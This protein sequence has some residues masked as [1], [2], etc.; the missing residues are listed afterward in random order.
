MGDIEIIPVEARNDLKKFINLP[1]SIYPS[2][3]N[4]VP[5][6]K[7]DLKRLLNTKKHPFWEFSKRELFIA[8]RCGKPI[9][10]IAAIVDENYNKYHQEKMGIWGFF[11]GY[12][13]HEAAKSLFNAAEEW[14]R[15]QGMEFI[16]GPLNPS[17]NYEVGLLIEGFEHFPA[18]MMPW[19]F[20][21]Y[22]ELVE[23]SGYTKEK[24]LFTFRIHETDPAGPRIERL[25]KRLLSKGH[26]TIRNISRKNYDSEIKLFT[27]LYNQAWAENWGFVPMSDG[28]IREMA[29]NLKRILDEDLVFFLLYDGKP[30]GV[31]MVLTDMNPLLKQADGRMGLFTGVKFLLRSRFAVGFRM[32]MAGVIKEFKRLGTPLALF[33][34]LN[35]L[36]RGHKQYEFLECGWT[37]EDNRDINELAIEMG[38]KRYSVY[39]IFRKSLV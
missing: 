28:E 23:D 19:N 30:A 7:S 11:E 1:W 15:L 36:L 16:R 12:N 13:D 24:D 27:R 37:L 35:K 29:R 4:W 39:R 32:A 9:G 21:Y 10:R 18:I 3:S 8:E 14:V 2:Q 5:P 34:H 22:R 25:G 38:A 20:P 17:T 26:V 33:H 6:L 31:V